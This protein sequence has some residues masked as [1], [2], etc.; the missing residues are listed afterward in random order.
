MRLPRLKTRLAALAL[1]GSAFAVSACGLEATAALP[2]S[3][4]P[5]SIKHQPELEGVQITVAS[6]DFTEQIILSY[7]TQ[8]AL[9]AAGADVVD[10]SNIA[11]SASARQALEKGEVDVTWEYTGTGWLNYLGQDE[12]I[13]DEQEMY[14]RVKAADL[15]ENGIVWLDYSELNNT[16]A[17]ALS[18]KSAKQLDVDTV[19]ELAEELRKR[20]NQ[21]VYCL[22][23]EFASRP[24]GMPG[25]VNTYDLPVTETKNFG[26]GAVYAA[27][28]DGNCQV[29]EVFTTDGRIL[30]L[31]LKV[32]EDDKQFF[33]Q[34]NAAPTLREDFYQENPKIA[35]VLKPIS[36]ALNNDEMIKMGARVDVDGESAPDVARDWLVDKGFVTNPS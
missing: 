35:E 17:F 11:G 16:Y 1:A 29:G 19:S 26:T 4:E 10:F 14:D 27:L 15:R 21:A 33:P 23:T 6:K 31:G 12:Q 20:P 3:V 22:E 25:A 9:Q 5:G 34:Y 24:D 2:F 30:A 32:L 13:P 18:K 28:N 36:D 7:I 8:L